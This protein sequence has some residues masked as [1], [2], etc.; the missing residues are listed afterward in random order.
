MTRTDR[1]VHLTHGT[2]ETIP[3]TGSHDHA[4]DHDHSSFIHV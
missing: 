4:D 3:A 2:R 1:S